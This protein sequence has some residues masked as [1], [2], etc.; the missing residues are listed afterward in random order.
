MRKEK[1]T[2]K[3]HFSSGFLRVSG[4]KKAFLRE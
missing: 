1:E 3:A 4:D 2:A